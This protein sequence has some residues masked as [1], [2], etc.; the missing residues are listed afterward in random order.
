MKRVIIYG[1]HYGTTKGYAEKFAEMMGISAINYQ[2]NPDLSGYD[3]II[4][5]GGLYAGGVK[6]LKNTIKALPQSAKLVI[7]TVGLADVAKKANTDHIKKSISQQVPESILEKTD[8]FHLRGGI[9]YSQLNFAH[10]TM[11][12]L[13]YK[14]AKNTPKEQQTAEIE[15]MIETYNKKV[16]FIDYD[17]LKPI[18]DFINQM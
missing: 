4:H 10:K 13:V 17:A 8:I 12:S 1:S 11:M 5:F 6:G 3:I 15:D 7:V 2:E 14:K 16:Y 18:A 9:D